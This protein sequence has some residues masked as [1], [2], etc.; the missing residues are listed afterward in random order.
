[1]AY[2]PGEGL[3]DP[4]GG[5]G[6]PA[7]APAG[8]GGGGT[9]SAALRRDGLRILRL[10]RFGARE[11][12]AV[13]PATG[14]AALAERARLDCVSAE[15]IWQEL[16]KLL[17]APQP[18]LWMP[19]EI[20]GQVLPWLDTAGQPARYATSLAVVDALPPD[21]L[22]RLAAPAG[23]RRPRGCAAG[24]ERPAVLPGPGRGGVCPGGGQRPAS[25][26]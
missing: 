24:G 26:R 13:E 7:G 21:P 25:D 1:M 6:G 5:R 23:S 17:A 9:R 20:L 18:G 16:Y 11:Q 15:R 3:I 22:V 2:A 4:F 14:R 12:L 10:Y 19:P 8:A